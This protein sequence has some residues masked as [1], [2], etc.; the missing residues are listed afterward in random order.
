MATNIRK[1]VQS[2]PHLAAETIKCDAQRV[3]EELE[4]HEEGIGLFRELVKLFLVPVTVR[5]LH[6]SRSP[7]C[8]LEYCMSERS[9]L[10]KAR[11]R[12]AEIG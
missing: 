4:N 3:E 12:A 1:R 8:E 6:N 7:M 9:S 2:S 11:M 5:V 10:E